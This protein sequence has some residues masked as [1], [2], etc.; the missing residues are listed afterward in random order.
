[1]I[2][3][4]KNYRI[5]YSLYYAWISYGQKPRSWTQ[6]KRTYAGNRRNTDVGMT[7]HGAVCGSGRCYALLLRI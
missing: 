7:N 2:Y 4:R 5:I 1:M 3:E 6:R